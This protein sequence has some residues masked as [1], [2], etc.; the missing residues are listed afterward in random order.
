MEIG[1]LN[2][3]NQHMRDIPLTMVRHNMDSLPLHSCPV[4]YS[5]RS[6]A[7]GDEGAWARIEAAAGA[8]PN[9]TAA[10]AQFLL[11][12]APAANRLPGRLLFLEHEEAGP[13][14]TTTA[15]YGEFEGESR[16][17]IHW[18][19][20]IPEHQG[21]GLAKPLL[22]AAM[23]QMAS[24][25]SSGYLTTETTSYRGINLYLG[26]GFEPVVETAL[27]REG[28]AIVEEILSRKIVSPEG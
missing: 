2:E 11:E 26:F 22:S 1:N 25:F 14:G 10:R 27:D 17:R 24:E 16:G 6:Y 21:R 23:S 13:I 15:W 20:I 5:V 18:V 3:R 7:P 4:G 12:Y 28:W 9:E 8:F 19:G